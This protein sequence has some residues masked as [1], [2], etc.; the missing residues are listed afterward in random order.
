MTTDVENR[1]KGLIA[2]MI[3]LAI[4]PFLI[5]FYNFF[6][7][8]TLPPHI[9]QYDK[10]QIVEID[11]LDVSKG[12]YFVEKGMTANQLLS[13][14]GSR[15]SAKNDFSLQSGMR[16]MLNSDQPENVIGREF[17][18][19]SKLAMGM[20]IDLNEACAEELILIPGVGVKTADKILNL[21]KEKNSF[22]NIEELMEIDGI[23]EKKLEKLRR[24]LYVRKNE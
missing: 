15:Y 12:M 8:H 10:F 6:H 22:R 2:I 11:D 20:P 19:V 4:S 24:Y 7:N 21:R 5:L 23:K 17:D 18:N 16:L 9:N 3:I 13:S 14:L 1:V